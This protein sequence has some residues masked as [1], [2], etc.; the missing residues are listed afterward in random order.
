MEVMASARLAQLVTISGF[1]LSV[2]VAL[3]V[4]PAHAQ[5]QGE[6]ALKPESDLMKR[7]DKAVVGGGFEMEGYWIWCPTVVKGDDGLYHMFASRWPKRLPFHPGWM[8]ASE[9]VHATSKTA[10]GPYRFSEVALPARGPQYWDG[11]STHNPKI[12]RHGS[13][14]VLFYMGSTHP[15]DDP[16]PEQLTLDSHFTTL[17]RASKRVGVAT[18]KS[19]FGPWTRRD[20][21]AL[22]T[23]PG[24]YY[25][26]LTSNPAAHIEKDGSV[27]MV[28]KSRAYKDKYPF[29]TPMFLGVAR[30]AHYDKPFSVVSEK[31]IFGVGHGG[32]V[33]DPYIWKDATGFHMIAKDQRGEITGERHGG[34]L[35]HSRDGVTW[36]VDPAPRAY[37]KR[38][39]FT[40]GTV[41]VMGQLERASVLIQDGVMTHMIFAAMD[42][43][44]GFQNGTRTWAQ[45]VRLKPP[46]ATAA[47][48]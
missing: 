18:A 10:E 26:F 27:V 15:F 43:S 4:R 48:R 12:V 14:W 1:C 11:R 2:G 36:K 46:P 35:A 6:A 24:T 16:K 19:P 33:E 39:T 30:A 23:R 47:S 40:D 29:Q 13:T 8:V 5:T 32:E 9:V 22:T 17:A 44:G 20:V 3:P 41:Q 7:I 34:L 37:S 31:P 25:S 28:F 42:G 21:P 38:L 45:V